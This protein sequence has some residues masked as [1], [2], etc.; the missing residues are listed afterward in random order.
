MMLNELFALIEERKAHPI[1][2][3][4]TNRLLQDG[5]DKILKKIGEEAVEVIVAAKGQ[6]D[7]R[8]VEETADLL[9]HVLVLL[10]SRDQSLA[11]VEAELR[12]RHINR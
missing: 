7:Q 9:Y 3:S 4:Y 8:V 1:V 12:R 2:G 11:D 6:G 10:A 5:E